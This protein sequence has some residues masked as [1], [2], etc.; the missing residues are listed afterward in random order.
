MATYINV[1]KKSALANGVMKTIVFEGKKIMIA[2]INGEYFA[3]GDTCTHA[4]CSLGTQGKLNGSVVTCG[5]HG[6][7]FD[8]TSG[9]VVSPPPQKNAVSYSVKV[10]GDDVMLLD[11]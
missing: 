4:G 8:V 2:N 10:E 6:G 9:S 1:I 7:Q 5:C 3:I 11:K